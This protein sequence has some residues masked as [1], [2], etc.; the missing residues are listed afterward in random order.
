MFMSDEYKTAWASK[1]NSQRTE[2]S[3]GYETPIGSL[4]RV[5]AKT[6]HIREGA[7]TSLKYYVTKS[8]VLFVRQGK[9]RIDYSSEMYHYQEPEHRKLKSVVL[10]TGDVFYVQSSCPYKITAIC[11]SEIIEIGDDQ[12]STVTK[13][14]EEIE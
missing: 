11:D 6:L 13:I 5:N 3:W 9:V 12:H 10:C 1:R 8:E 14:D 2:R 4:S 7:S